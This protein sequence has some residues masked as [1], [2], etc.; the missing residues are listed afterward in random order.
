[1]RKGSRRD[2][3]NALIILTTN[4]GDTVVEKAAM[5]DPPPF[6]DEFHQSLTRALGQQF[7]AAFHRPPSARA[8]LAH[9]EKTR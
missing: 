8:V 5:T 4:A 2:F 1:M 6:E 9:S 7:P 3:S